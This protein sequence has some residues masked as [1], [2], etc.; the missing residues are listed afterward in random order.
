MLQSCAA[1]DATQ[2]WSVEALCGATMSGRNLWFGRAKG[3]RRT[4]LIRASLRGQYDNAPASA[5]PALLWQLQRD[6]A[7]ANNDGTGKRLL[8]E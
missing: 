1:S 7:G 3:R 5:P 2:P 8:R 6:R 4:D